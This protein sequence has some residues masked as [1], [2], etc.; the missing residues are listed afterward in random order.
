MNMH[1]ELNHDRSGVLETT[2]SATFTP[3]ANRK[4][5]A[6]G[7]AWLFLLPTLPLDRVLCLGTPARTTLAALAAFSDQVTV[8]DADTRQTE[9]EHVA[10]EAFSPEAFLQWPDASVD[11]VLLVG[12]Q[13]TA[14]AGRPG[15]L[16]AQL[17]RLLKPDGWLHYEYA[18]S[19]DP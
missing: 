4:G 15:W 18:L 16:Q 17:R 10:W 12:R 6:A 1:L 2:L 8:L 9:W 19:P 3:S 14:Q 11:L 5:E 13:H 7:A